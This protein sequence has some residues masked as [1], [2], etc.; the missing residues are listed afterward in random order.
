MNASDHNN[1]MDLLEQRASDVE[2]SR[3]Q[4]PAET[5]LITQ[6]VK[7]MSDKAMQGR[8]DTTQAEKNEDPGSRSAVRRLAVF[9]VENDVR[10]PCGG[11]EQMN[12]G[13]RRE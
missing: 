13:Y 3:Q 7:P 12:N 5:H 9:W 6:R 2:N 4:E 11:N 10:R 8:D 1:V